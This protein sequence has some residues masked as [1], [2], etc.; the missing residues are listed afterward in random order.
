M[1]FYDVIHTPE[2]QWEFW[3]RI[4]DVKFMIKFVLICALE[5]QKFWLRSCRV[6][7][8]MEEGWRWRC[9]CVYLFL[10]HC[11]SCLFL[12]WR[13]TSSIFRLVLFAVSLNTHLSGNSHLSAF[14]ASDTYLPTYINKQQQGAI[15]TLILLQTSSSK[16]DIF[17]RLEENRDQG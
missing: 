13:L 6:K 9:G 14:S 16:H 2:S 7:L 12:F 17:S 15:P 11:Y 1:L 8:L 3:I 4:N 10:F 5:A